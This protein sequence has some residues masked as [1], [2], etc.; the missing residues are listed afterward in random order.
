MSEAPR[1]RLEAASVFVFS[2]A[3]LG[4]QI[5]WTRIF[6]FMIWY[7][8]AFLVISVSMLGFTAGGLIL[9]RRPRLLRRPFHDL[10]FRAAV[11]FALASA[12]AL[13]VIC[14]LPFD[15]SILQSWRNFLLFVALILV[16]TGEFVFAG[17]FV[18]FAIVKAPERVAWTYFANMSGSGVGCFLSVL[19]LDR[20][21]PAATLLAFSLVALLAGLLLVPLAERRRGPAATAALAGALL[22][23]AFT[24]ALD[25]LAEPFF[26]SSVK[27]YPHIP[28][29]DIER[30]T[31]NSLAI[32]DF[33]RHRATRGLW[34][35]S[36]RK[37]LRDHPDGAVP[38]RVGL[39][40]DG[41]ALTFAYHSPG[42]ITAEPIFD[43]LPATLAYNV[44][45][46]RD[47]LVIGA[48]GGLDVVC[49]LRRGAERVT[50]V[51]INPIMIRA[52]LGPLADFNGRIFQRPG[53]VPV[54]AEGR[55]YLTASGD[56]KWDLIQLSGVDTLAASQAG[57]FTLAENYLYTRE[58]FET[59]LRHLRPGGIL[60]LTRWMYEPP[61][62]T[63]RV[64]SVADAALTR[65]GRDTERHMVMIASGSGGFSVSLISEAPFTPAQSQRVMEVCR[66]KGYVPLAVP[67]VD[68]SLPGR[69][70]NLFQ[71]LI[72]RD[73]AGKR[74][75]VDTYPFDISVTTDDR[76]FFFEHSR[77]RSAWKYRD[78]ILDRS[79]GHGLLIVTTLVVA[80]LAWVFIA[81]P[82]RPVLE[83]ASGGAGR[84]AALAFFSGLGLGYV[85]IEIVLVQK[86]TLFLGNPAY[87]LAVVLFAM[88]VFSG[89]GSTLSVRL[90]GTAAARILGAC[91]GI[92]ATLL[93][94]G[95]G[96]DPILDG[97]LRLDLPAR[98]ATTLG[99]L[100]PPAIL[101]GIPFPTAIRSLGEAGREDLVVRGWVVNGYFSVLGSC[102]A[103]VI[104]IGLGFHV[105]LATGAAVYLAAGLTVP[106][107]LAVAGPARAARA[108]A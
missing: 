92:A 32:V 52:G 31:G 89:I 50:A 46:P 36:Y 77:W 93:A 17:L 98:I 81:A 16:V 70:E 105:V 5:V 83:G 62:Q 90:P 53:V 28:K 35:L 66:K 80:L 97:A 45:T 21:I 94:Y 9:H 51:D 82:A 79:N 7:H 59:Y 108:A 23:A 102:L 15:G 95:A 55:S 30:R 99:L 48:G 68:V 63:L 29:K 43:Y 22:A 25:P 72:R 6:S 54:V 56:R 47:V 74:A 91:L 44:A 61:R 86:L 42:E 65:L 40:I 3:A 106:K 20:M 10:S 38:D 57:A 75:F 84:G 19:L 24:T 85:L 69:R 37:F 14:K 64:V 26:M 4:V 49:A 58:A 60:T 104:S 71:E 78:T 67:G 13:L 107:W 100:G 11:G 8:F 34:G 12:G 96:L 2:V 33:F 27:S 88:L 1:R 73:R 39:L 41:W 76:P 87:A 101:M 18:A 103:M